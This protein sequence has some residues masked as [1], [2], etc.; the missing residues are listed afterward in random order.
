MRIAID[1]QSTLGR[2]TGIGLYTANLLRALRRVAPEHEYVELSW[3]RTEELRTDRRLRWEQWELPRRVRAARAQVLHLTGFGAPIRRP[4][5]TVLTVHDLI[6]YLFPANLPPVA[7][8]YW[9]RWLPFSVR[10]AGRIIA[11]S[12]HTRGDLQRL[13]SIQEERITVIPLAADERFRPITDPV[14]RADVRDRYDLPSSFILYVGTLEP[15]KGLDTLV[16]AF[17]AL[18]GDF[19]HALVIAG[20]KGWYTLPLFRQVE[21][22]GLRHRIRFTDYVDDADL[23]VVYN[24]ADIF[25]FPSRYEGFGLPPL[26]AMAC[27]VPVVSSNAASL[28]EV[29]GDAGVLVSPDNVEALAAA[30]R[31]LL[32]NEAQRMDLCARGLTRASRF[33]WEETARQT[34]RVYEGLA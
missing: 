16:N 9:A 2:K 5:P 1:T 10:F 30:M 14:V 27:G 32:V 33:T 26:E 18:A 34:A 23:P 13:L 6:G 28:P 19:P 4:C 15:R 25:V 21:A 7:R 24:L 11:D 22:L 29:V 3:G 17:A 12:E 8:F 31:Q 20:K